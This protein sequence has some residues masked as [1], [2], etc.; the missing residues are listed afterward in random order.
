MMWNNLEPIILYILILIF[1]KTDTISNV[2]IC[3]YIV[4][5]IIYTMCIWN[6]VN[7]TGVYYRKNNIKNSLFWEWNY[8]KESPYFYVIFLLVLLVL[9]NQNFHGWIKNICLFFTLFTFFFSYYKYQIDKGVGRFWCYF[10]AHL[11]IF[12][13]LFSFIYEYVIIKN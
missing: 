11:P 7:K 10:A 6:Q 1:M 12:F 8:K 3:I 5:M 2:S 4:L 13:M 9:I